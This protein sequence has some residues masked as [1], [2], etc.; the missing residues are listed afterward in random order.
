MKIRVTS[1]PQNEGDEDDKTGLLTGFSV[2]FAGEIM[3]GGAIVLIL[4]IAILLGLSLLN[5]NNSRGVAG[6]PGD[7]AG[8][9]EEAVG[10]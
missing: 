4:L 5:S 8:K 10:Y 3:L 1:T 7:V 6:N 9:S 2:L